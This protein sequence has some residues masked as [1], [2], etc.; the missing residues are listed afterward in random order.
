MVLVSMTGA[1]V[2][3]NTP[4]QTI[5]VNGGDNVTLVCAYTGID[6]DLEFKVE[7]TRDSKALWVYTFNSS[8]VTTDEQFFF[9]HLS[10]ERVNKGSEQFNMSCGSPM[11]L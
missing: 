5:H 3:N 4:R 11:L 6:P 2:S 8:H 10:M 1:A 7:F 9:V